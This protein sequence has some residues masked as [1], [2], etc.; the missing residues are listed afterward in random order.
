MT[1]VP[2]SVV[3]DLGSKISLSLPFII[4]LVVAKY[5]CI[6]IAYLVSPTNII[7]RYAASVQLL[8]NATHVVISLCILPFLVHISLLDDHLDL[9]KPYFHSRAFGLSA[10][11]SLITVVCS[12]YPFH[13]LLA[14][15]TLGSLSSLCSSFVVSTVALCL[16]VALRDTAYGGSWNLILRLAIVLISIWICTDTLASCPTMRHGHVLLFIVCFTWMLTYI[17]ISAFGCVIR[18]LFSNERRGRGWWEVLKSV[19]FPLLGVVYNRLPYDRTSKFWRVC[20][21]CIRREH[22]CDPPK[23]T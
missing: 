4:F 16:D 2:T 3:L 22:T 10:M 7:R 20:L 23:Q 21:R 17:S 18:S 5:L 15:S 12:C 14:L 6:S 13:T 9:C 8:L 1:P 19:L 11:L